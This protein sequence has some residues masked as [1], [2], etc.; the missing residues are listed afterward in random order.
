M[1][2]GM[3]DEQDTPQMIHLNELLEEELAF[4]KHNLFFKHHIKVH[5]TFSATLP[6]LRGYYFH[7]SQ[8]L[9]NV[10]QNAIEAMENSSIKELSLITETRN[11][12]MRVI[13]K[14]TGC[15]ILE[16][17]KA[18]L[19][20]PFITNKEKHDGLGLFLTQELLKPYGTSFHHSS[21]KGETIFEISFPYPQDLVRDK[22]L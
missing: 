2:K 12:Q 16:E 3:H 6:P 14:D 19:F 11:N 21:Q 18:N 9:L 7:F 8:G 15:G 22:K 4:L 1:Q 13:I 5:K 20:K 10:I 17:I